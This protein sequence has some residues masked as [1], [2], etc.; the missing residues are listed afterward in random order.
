MAIL[1]AFGPGKPIAV[2]PVESTGEKPKWIWYAVGAVIGLGLI[3]ILRRGSSSTSTGTPL[4][5]TPT[6]AQGQLDNLTAA[7]GALQGQI[8]PP[9]ANAPTP[10]YNPNNAADVL[11][12][13]VYGNNTAT[14]N[15]PL[16]EIIRGNLTWQAQGNIGNYTPAQADIFWHRV[17]GQTSPTP[18]DVNYIAKGHL[19]A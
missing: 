19:N 5:T 9:S 17:L 3:V 12:H 1:P 7:I 10:L 8:G 4:A 18:G 14:P 16:N 11:W 13:E 2:K 15:V 6:A